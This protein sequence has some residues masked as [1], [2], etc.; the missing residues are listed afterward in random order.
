V[1]RQEPCPIIVLAPFSHSGQEPKPDVAT[2]EEHY[3]YQVE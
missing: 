3:A 1:A 2:H